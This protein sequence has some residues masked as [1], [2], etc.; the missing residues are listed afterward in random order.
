MNY[1]YDIILNFN[2]NLYDFYEWTEEDCPEFILKIPVFKVDDNTFIDMAKNDIRV[3]NA[4]LSK[5][6]N[7]TE[8][9]SPNS[10]KIIKYACVFTTLQSAIGIEFDENGNNKMKSNLS[11]EEE[12]ETLELTQLLK[13]SIIDYKLIEKSVKYNEFYTRKEKKLC[14]FLEN[15]I[16][17]IYKNKEFEKL[18]YIFYEIFGTKDNDINKIYFKL[19]HII[20][21]KSS[22]MLKIKEILDITNSNKIMRGNS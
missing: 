11:P 15:N 9:Y 13:Y 22:K 19:L 14:N 17:E 1:I 18:K 8:V 5:I 4:F 21:D 7:Q 2:K 10:L 6:I 3:S 12:D 20:K 16:N